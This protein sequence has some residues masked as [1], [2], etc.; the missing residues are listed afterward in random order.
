MKNRGLWFSIVMAFSLASGVSALAQTEA[1]PSA[2]PATPSTSAIPAVM[3][4][5]PTT[6]AA[7][8]APAINTTAE[9]MA[10]IYVTGSAIP[11][12]D[13]EGASPVTVIDS[14]AIQQRGYQTVEDVVRHLP[15]NSAGSSPGQTSLAFASGAAYASLDGLGPQATLVLINGRRVSDYAANAQNEFGFVDLNSIPA[16]I[17]D[18]I[19]VLTEGTALYGS[20]AVAGVINIITKKN[21]GTENGEVDTY[22]GNTTSEDAFEQRY[23]VMGNLESFDKNGFGVVEIDYK[24]QNSILGQDRAISADEDKTSMGGFNLRS[25]NTFPGV[26]YSET[27]GQE[28][29]LTPNSGN[30]PLIGTGPAGMVTDPRLTTPYNTLQN[31]ASLTSIVPETDRYGAYLNYT[32]KFYDG[33]ITPNV[34][35]DYRHNRTI[36]QAAQQPIYYGDFAAPD[37]SPALGPFTY[38][39][40]T[41][42]PYNHSGQAIDLVGYR[43]LDGSPRID[44]TN[45]DVFRAVPSVDIKLGEGWT[46]N[47]GFNY[48]YTYLNEREINNVSGPKFQ[49][50]LDSTDPAT[51]FNPF[52]TSVGGNSQSVINSLYESSGNKDTSSEISEDFRLNG[53]LFDLP[54]GPVQMAFGG[55]YRLT[56]FNQSYDNTDLEGVLVGSSVQHDN[57]LS[58]KALAGYTEVD[59]PLTSPSFNIPGFYSTD[60]QVSGRVDKYTSFGTTENPQVRLR[61]ETIPGLVLRAGYSTAFRIPSLSETGTTGNSAFTVITDPNYGGPGVASPSEVVENVVGNAKLAPETAEIWTGGVAYSPQ[62]I[63]GLLLTAD[64]FDI[65]YKNQIETGSAQSEVD[66]E[67]GNPNVV[68]NSLGQVVSVTVPYENVA[69]SFI[70]GVN[71]G[72][73]Y[74]IGD[75]EVNFGQFT[76][77]VNG[78]YI[79]RSIQDLGNGPVSVVGNDISQTEASLGPLPRYKQEATIVWDYHN[80]EFVLSNDYAA[81]YTDTGAQLGV[82][83]LAQPDGAQIDRNVAANVVFNMQ[84]SYT[85]DQQEMDK[86]MPTSRSDG[87][88][89]QGILAGTRL[90]VGCDNVWDFQP[91]FTANTGDNLGYD[92]T[93][94][95][96]TGRFIYGEISKKF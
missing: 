30:G 19:E 17:V 34:D 51:A 36:A 54:A 65:R 57:A 23:T 28:F 1:S 56:R 94:A 27:S 14:A 48:S 72:A 5:T 44:S 83:G 95:D 49:A 71:I 18:R 4:P 73:N 50:A 86:W 69:N 53:K 82:S 29:S 20:D 8:P 87:F 59:I 2:P 84:A 15:A 40:P 88:D 58:Q 62:F 75:P 42:N 63:K 10:P 90:S 7:G 91:P 41:T 96:P 16:Q 70:H 24:H 47:A 43:L 9:Q 79:L 11:T 76:F 77:T 13:T 35:F 85:F 37:T 64:W 26:F 32:Y 25:Y 60:L 55:E 22:I 46:L 93:F 66:M 45:S 74:V 3:S 39:I 21:L 6:G 92:P 68:L 67:A 81:G 12:T 89:W 31:T 80:F 52:T 78:S 38:I 61:L 33:N